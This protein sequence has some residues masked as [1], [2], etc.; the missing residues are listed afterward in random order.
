MI[1]LRKHRK[2]MQGKDMQGYIC[3][4]LHILPLGLFCEWCLLFTFFPLEVS[5]MIHKVFGGLGDKARWA[6]IWGLGQN[7]LCSVPSGGRVKP[8][9]RFFLG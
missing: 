2:E 3:W 4:L 5:D 9:L 8:P 7:W 1:L 6:L